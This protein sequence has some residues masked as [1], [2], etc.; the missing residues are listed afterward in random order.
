MIIAPKFSE[1]DYNLS[2]SFIKVI[3]GKIELHM[4]TKDYD[5]SFNN[6][7]RTIDNITS[8]TKLD[9]VVLHLPFTLHTFELITLSDTNFINF[10]SFIRRV[11]EYSYRKNIN[12]GILLHQ[13]NSLEL[14]DSI[15]PTYSKVYDILNYIDSDKV[16]LLVENCLPHLND[17][18]LT[19]VHSFEL[20]NKIQ[21]SKLKACIDVCHGRCHENVLGV[22]FTIPEEIAKRVIWVHFADTRNKDGYRDKSTHGV[23]HISTH[24]ILKDLEMLSFYGI[25]IQK[26]PLVPEVQDFDRILRPN[27]VKEIKLLN[28]VRSNFTY[29]GEIG[30]I[31][32]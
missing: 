12:I 19:K 20:L 29:I 26:V 9:E 22:R 25:D 2:E 31:S 16:Y 27:M 8:R 28:L 17:N 10:K 32:V 13:E 30:Y 4:D 7:I 21:H 3:E 6:C 11:E 1:Y 15:D 18:I 14:L 23:I 5:K 24:Q